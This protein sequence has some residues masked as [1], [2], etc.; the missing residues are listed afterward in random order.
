[1]MDFKRGLVD[2]SKSK[3]EMQ[4]KNK[5]QDLKSLLNETGKGLAKIAELMQAQPGLSEKDKMQMQELLG[6]YVDFVE[7][8]LGGEGEDSESEPMSEAEGQGQ[9]PME[10]GMHGK[11][12]N[13]A[14]R[15]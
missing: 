3:E 2:I 14:M 11:P 5:E 12:M 9:V 6:Q 8:K 1:M 10:G 13:M 4:G 7:S 15:Q